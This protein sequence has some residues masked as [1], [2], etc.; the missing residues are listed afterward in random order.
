MP[1]TNTEKG[2]TLTPELRLFALVNDS[3]ELNRAVNLIG[4]LVA[5]SVLN[6]RVDKF[7]F[8]LERGALR[9]CDPG[10]GAL[11]RVAVFLGKDRARSISFY[12]SQWRAP[13]QRVIIK[14]VD[15]SEWTSWVTGSMNNKTVCTNLGLQV[16]VNESVKHLLREMAA[17]LIS[18]DK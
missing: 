17:Q 9:R 14:E 8:T 7:G 2:L 6:Y 12:D 4:S 16:A 5:E 11:I 1:V 3:W 13:E 15:D 10:R 18:C